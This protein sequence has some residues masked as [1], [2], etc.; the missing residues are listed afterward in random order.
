MPFGIVCSFLTWLCHRAPCCP[1]QVEAWFF[2]PDL[3]SS[4]PL[5]PPA[6]C[7]GV[8]LSL[9]T[10]RVYGFSCATNS[11]GGFCKGHTSLL[12]QNSLSTRYPECSPPL[13]PLDRSKDLPFLSLGTVGM[14]WG[15]DHRDFTPQTH[16]HPLAL[17]SPQGDSE[18]EVMLTTKTPKATVGGLSP[19]KEYTVQIFA[20]SSSGHVLLARRE[21]VIK[22]L[23]SY[24]VSRNSQRPWGAALE[25]TPSLVGSPDL[26]PTLEPRVAW[27]PSHDLPILGV[28][29]EEQPTQV[30]GT[31]PAQLALNPKKQHHFMV[32]AA[33]R[34]KSG[35]PF[36]CTPAVPMDMV[37][38]VDGSW[39]T[40]HRNFQLIK[41]FLASVV[42]PFEIDPNKVQVGLTQYSGDPQTEWDLNS[43]STK[44]E[45][46]SAIGRLHYKG[47][48]M[49]TGLALTHV[50]EQN[51]RPAAGLRVEAVKVVVLLTDGKSQ[52]DACTA[53]RVLKSL[54]TDVFTVGV[55]NA[56]EAEL[57]LLASQPLDITVHN[58]LDFPQLGTL[59]S[60]LSR[61]ICHHVQG[62]GPRQRDP[63]SP[64]AAAPA[65]DSLPAPTG[66]VL[67]PVTCSSIRLS[68]T[69]VPQPPLKY[70]IV[71]RPSR[72]SAPREVVVETPTSS[73]ELR[74]LT[75]STEYLISVLP[76]YA[77]G[78][79]EGLQ[80]LAT[81][82]AL[83]PPRHL[84]FENVTHNSARVLW[85]GPQTP[86]RL[87]R[88]T[89]I[90][91]KGDHLGQVREALPAPGVYFG[92]Y[93]GQRPQGDSAPM[94]D[95]VFMGVLSAYVK[96]WHPRENPLPMWGP[97]THGE[98]QD[99]QGA[100]YPRG[101]PVTQEDKTLMG[102]PST[103]A[104][105]CIY[106]EPSACGGPGT[107]QPPSSVP[108][109]QY[110]LGTW[111]RC[112]G[113]GQHGQTTLGQLVW[114]GWGRQPAA[115]THTG[116]TRGTRGLKGWRGRTGLM[117]GGSVPPHAH[118][119]SVPSRPRRPVVSSWW[120][121]GR[122]GQSV[123]VWMPPWQWPWAW[124][125]SRGAAPRSGKVS[126]A[127]ARAPPR[128][129][130]LQVEIPG[131]ASS[132]TLGPL[133][134]STTYTVRVTCVYPGGG[135]SALTSRVTTQK[136]PSPSQLTVMEMPGDEVQLEWAAAAASDVLV[137]QIK[138]TPLSDGKAHEVRGGQRLGPIH[139]WTPSFRE[140]SPPTPSSPERGRG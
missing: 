135:S 34:R 72:G 94:G 56:D 69:P 125:S 4:P 107:Q 119:G 66:L 118:L 108:S 137:Y 53:A 43:F 67:T 75:S 129:A 6:H 136:V 59:S 87:C 13:G 81:T 33:D 95:E 10:S 46:F 80:G 20:L 98:T 31:A 12:P 100:Q 70:L 102:R 122:P 88:A 93:R 110:P 57:R 91:S 32:S 130:R 78:V 54:S 124:V 5:S 86:A 28:P 77:G 17:P 45:V 2:L 121:L 97:S 89:Y 105:T 41:D 49:F 114:W 22:D 44:E 115:D 61:L 120:G 90:S 134:S 1:G 8:P 55:K 14:S 103:Y 85:E 74:N 19:S 62:R 71:W 40:G 140:A 21:F 123:L 58:V 51:L 68:W 126:E 111:L 64:A 131:N 47:G 30:E 65:L 36:H 9:G 113:A 24:S 84:D 15:K 37:F 128:P 133:S 116:Q 82:S 96:T 127:P 139:S 76:V 117:L 101:D 138:W 92:A 16:V 99:L 112:Q 7:G 26:E 48:N 23:K 42:S 106:R 109:P 50:L 18:Q 52:D 79:G 63:V 3:G 25:P 27:A 35:A 83:A 29:L 39:S 132:A 104:R 73:A 38:L 11:S 60:L